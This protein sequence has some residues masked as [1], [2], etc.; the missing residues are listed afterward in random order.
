MHDP[1]VGPDDARL[2]KCYATVVAFL[3][4]NRNVFIPWGARMR[5]RGNLVPAQRARIKSVSMLSE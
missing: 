1:V 3:Q 2:G 4:D 5:L